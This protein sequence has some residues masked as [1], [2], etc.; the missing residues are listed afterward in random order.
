MQ[1]SLI[2]RAVGDIRQSGALTLDSHVLLSSAAAVVLDAEGNELGSNFSLS[3]H[4]A[5]LVSGGA[6]TLGGNISVTDALTISAGG[7]IVQ[8]APVS[9][10]G[11]SVLLSSAGVIN[12]NNPSN[13]VEY[14]QLSA[15]SATLATST[16]FTLNQNIS[17]VTGLSVT[18][19]GILSSRRR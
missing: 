2:I 7:S 13:I 16:G 9:L 4:T 17:V 10:I 12:L 11:G 5:T 3:A 8:T 19:R 15:A 1:T 14:L 18:A 6:L